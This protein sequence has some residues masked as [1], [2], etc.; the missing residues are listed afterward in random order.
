M[1]LRRPVPFC[2]LDGPA[3]TLASWR[4]IGPAK[5]FKCYSEPSDM[6]VETTVG[7]VCCDTNCLRES[8]FVRPSVR[9]RFRRTEDS[10]P[11]RDDWFTRASSWNMSNWAEYGIWKARSQL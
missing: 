6:V 1:P 5:D 8:E 10:L 4:V 9:P 3:L 11:L 7:T 2:R